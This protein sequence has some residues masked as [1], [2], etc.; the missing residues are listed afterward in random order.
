MEI[1]RKLKNVRFVARLRY[2]KWE[3]GNE[4]EEK[5]MNQEPIEKSFIQFMTRMENLKIEID[6]FKNINDPLVF[7]AWDL[8]TKAERPIQY[9]I[10]VGNDFCSGAQRL[11]DE[12]KKGKGKKAPGI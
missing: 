1:I 3:I 4:S 5:E 11:L 2:G 8:Y 10:Q 12:A 7:S 6:K 9:G